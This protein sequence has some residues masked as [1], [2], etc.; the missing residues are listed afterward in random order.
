MSRAQMQ[1]IQINNSI[2]YN[3]AQIYTIMLQQNYKL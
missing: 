2:T 1:Y 3:L